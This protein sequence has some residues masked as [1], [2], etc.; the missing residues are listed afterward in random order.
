MLKNRTWFTENTEILT[1]TGW[2]TIKN[3]KKLDNLIV[4]GDKLETGKILEFNTYYYRGDIKLYKSLDLKFTCKELI[5]LDLWRVGKT[6]ELPI[7]KSKYYEGKL[8][9][10]VTNT[11]NI[12]AR[13]LFD[14][15]DNDDYILTTCICQNA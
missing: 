5:A 12:I 2:E 9:N 7:P 10:I 14:G 4:L 8:Y 11:N 3:I 15:L 6:V 13:S 1:T